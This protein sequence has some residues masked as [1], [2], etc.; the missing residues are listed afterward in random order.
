MNKYKYNVKNNN[1]VCLTGLVLYLSLSSFC[2]P[3]LTRTSLHTHLKTKTTM[4]SIWITALTLAAGVLSSPL[5]AAGPQI[6]TEKRQ[7][8]NLS[9]IFPDLLHAIQSQTGAIGQSPSP[10]PVR[11]A[12]GKGY[13]TGADRSINTPQTGSS[14]S[15]QAPSRATWPSKLPKRSARTS[16]TSLG[17]C[18][19]PTQP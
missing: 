15:T 12:Y 6:Q 19:P 11:P 18:A 3:F 16:T 10:V 7:I 2:C 1:K 13:T 9:T 14:T 5:A 8:G 17:R 4:K